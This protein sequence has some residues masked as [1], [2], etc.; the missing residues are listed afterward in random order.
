MVIRR[1]KKSR[2]WNKPFM[3]EIWNWD[4]LRL[5][6]AVSRASGLAGAVSSTGVSA[7]TLSRRMTT[8]ERSLG[9]TLFTR[10]RDGYDLTAAGKDLFGHAET[11]EQ[12][13]LGVERWR[14]ASDP[15]PVIKIAAGA[16]TSGFLARHL[17]DLIGAKDSIMLE[18]LAG[19]AS[20]DLL[21][22]EANIGLRNRR[23]TSI[24]LAGRKLGTVAFAVY[25]QTQLV[26]KQPQTRDN[27]RFT[28]CRWVALSSPGPKVPSAAWL[29]RRLSQV[30]KVICSNAHAVLE[31]AKAGAG[32]AVLPCFVG[33][34]AAGLTRASEPIDELAHEQWLVT[35]DDD[36]HDKEIKKMTRRIATL[37]RSQAPLFR[38]DLKS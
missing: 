16:W 31:A 19:T 3:N 8:L 10:R 25:G 18:L 35:H 21:R 34:S 30:R 36:R 23:P 20:A 6:L 22:R 15:R 17:P 28:D 9:V 13:A 11:L 33:D 5:F 12:G 14:T 29:D 4:D 37:I 2:Y 24:G 7:P 38:G 27:R 26:R 32:L 1:K